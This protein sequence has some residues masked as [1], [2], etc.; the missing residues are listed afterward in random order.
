MR[1]S[2][3]PM[4]G[5]L[6]NGAAMIEV[7]ELRFSGTGCVKA[8][9][10][11]ARTE[12]LGVRERRQTP[13][14][15]VHRVDEFPIGYSWQVALR[16]SLLPLHRSRLIVRERSVDGKNYFQPVRLVT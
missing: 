3:D 13:S 6:M 8:R 2:I 4:N 1:K 14:L 15:P 10:E 5:P 7:A 16:Q 12:L 11:R 9:I